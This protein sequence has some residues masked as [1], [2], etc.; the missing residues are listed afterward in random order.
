MEETYS[1]Y[2]DGCPLCGGANNN[3]LYNG[4]DFQE[5]E[6]GWYAHIEKE[7]DNED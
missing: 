3:R 6:C 4:A 5:C 2:Q 7:S 1:Q